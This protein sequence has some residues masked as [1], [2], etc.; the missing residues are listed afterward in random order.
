MRLALA[1][2]LVTALPARAAIVAVAPLPG[3]DRLRPE[4]SLVA[5]FD[6]D[7]APSEVVMQARGSLTGEHAGHVVVSDDRR[8]AVFRPDRPFAPG[9]RV[10]AAVVAPESRNF[11]FAIAPG[12]AP[13]IDPLSLLGAPADSLPADFPALTTTVSGPTAPGRLFLASFGIRPGTPSYLMILDDAG[14]P[15]FQRRR[16]APC[17]DFKLQPNGL[18][19]WFDGELQHFVAMDSTFAIVDSFA[20]G[21]GYPTDGHELRLLPNGHALLL[22]FDPQVVDMSQV[23]PG[24]N[25]KATVLGMILQELDAAKN[26]VFQWRSWDH[27]AIT[28]ATYE[29]LTAATVDYVHSNA[30]EVDADGN[31]LLS[32]RHMDEITKI[33]RTTGDTIWR[34]GGKHNEFTFTGDPLGFSHQHAIRR[35]GDGRYTLFD[36]GNNH[37]FHLS[38]ALEYELD[39][40]ARTARLAWSFLNST[41]TNAFAM[42][43]VQR[44][45]N[46]N[47]LVSNG[48]GSP[49]AIEVAPDGKRVFE[50]DLPAGTFSYRVFR[51]PWGETAV[52]RLALSSGFPNPSRGRTRLTARLPGP[53]TVSVDVYDVAGRRVMGVLRGRPEPAGDLAIDL[54][55]TSL[56]AGLY[57][58]RL[59]AGTQSLTR[60]VVRVH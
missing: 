51:L 55:L 44:L 1:V 29:D 28:D 40:P 18:L 35:I 33:D 27:F 20:C 31:F 60:R 2:I 23:V 8:I 3:S 46:G 30:I 11:A 45:P 37:P 22:G 52:P 47:T 16:A 6:R 48:T 39:Q 9:E 53:A 21:N 38:R 7:V 56:P 10:E 26:V 17:L 57:L 59:D 58:C 24:G 36:N 32:S 4:T 54:D 13:S 5:R 25:P 34:W 42:G 43:Y 14:K 12:A 41:D 49:S 15:L 50:L 19:T